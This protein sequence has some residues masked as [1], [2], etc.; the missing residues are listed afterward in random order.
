VVADYFERVVVLDR[1][2]LPE[3]A[4]PRAGVPQGKHPHALLAGG[5]RALDDL[6]PGFVHDLVQTGAVPLRV[7]LDVR[8]ESP[9]YDPFPQ[10]DL[11]WDVYAQS[12][13]Q[14][15]LSLRQRLRTYANIEV[16]QRCRVQECLAHADGTAVTGV[17]CL[18]ADGKSATLEADLVIDA[19]GRGT[20]TLGLLKAIG[21]A[22]PAETTIGVDLAYATAIFTIPEAAPE[23]WKSVFCFPQAPKN[24]LGALLLPT[25][26]ERWIVTIARMHGEALPGDADGFMA[27]VQQLRTPTIYNA[28]TSARPLGEIARFQF[29]ASEYRH[30]E[31]LE[32]FP[33]GLLPIGDAL[34]RFNPIYG[35]GMSV[36]AQEAQAL[37][38]LLAAR[39]GAGDPLDGLAT[40]F[41]AEAS[42]LIDGPWA[43]SAIPAFAHPSTRGE[44]PADLEQQLRVSFAVNKLAAYDPAVHKLLAEVQH[45]LKP[46]SVL[47]AP[48][49]GQRIQAVLAER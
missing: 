21:W 41:F 18:L 10:R 40:A 24:D 39:A 13:A 5:Q 14:L 29:P 17:Q 4:E 23:D 19:S 3:R 35:Q 2:A 33:R 8:I 32:A 15:E 42:T 20:L 31:R 46:R 44:R 12:R 26:G 48:E 27:C 38:Q 30:Y 49:L 45:L 11:G 6:F 28:L 7:G 43:M 16:R 36:A 37:Q 25:E 22:L 9:G 47:Q 34:C 1:D